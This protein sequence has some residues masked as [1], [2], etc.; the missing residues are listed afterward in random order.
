MK[1]TIFYLFLIFLVGCGIQDTIINEETNTQKNQEEYTDKELSIPEQN[2][3]ENTDKNTIS[4]IVTRVVDGD[5]IKLE[6]DGQ[7]ET[8][9]LLLVDTPETKHP[10]YPVQPLGEKAT[11]FAIDKLAGKTVEIEYD[12]PKRDKYDRI[13][14]YLWVDG[15]NFNEML[16]EEGLAR[17]AYVYDPPYTHEFSMRQ[18]EKKAKNSEKGIWGIENYVT[19]DG[20]NRVTREEQ[21]T[22]IQNDSKSDEND[23][24]F[25]NCTAAHAANVTPLYKG[26]PGYGTHMDGDGDGV[27]C[28]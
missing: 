19:E 28:E 17:F 9:R 12:G 16:L 25:E 27:A 26:D 4:A 7:E 6:V 22:T 21:Q 13:L 18:A 24:Y 3:A 15:E 2:N 20:F 1:S 8:A 14:V 23:I 11:N 5:T 10:E